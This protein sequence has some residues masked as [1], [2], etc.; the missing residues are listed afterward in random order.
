MYA[1][2]SI[3]PNYLEDCRDEPR[4]GITDYCGSGHSRYE[5]YESS[6]SGVRR[7]IYSAKYEYAVSNGQIVL[8]SIKISRYVQ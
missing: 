1:S 6:L 5:T 7:L 8:E 2:T 4:D 3:K